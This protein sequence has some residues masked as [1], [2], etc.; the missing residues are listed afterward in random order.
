MV[1]LSVAFAALAAITSFN[2]LRSANPERVD[3]T[4]TYMRQSTG[5][6]AAL[7]TAVSAVLDALYLI[8]RATNGGSPAAAGPPLRQGSPLRLGRPV[9][10]GDAG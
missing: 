2:R 1:V 7:V 3:G 8:T 6:L 10:E 5:V 4:V 9:Q